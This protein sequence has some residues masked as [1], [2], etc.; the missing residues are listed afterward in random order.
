[1]KPDVVY[2]NL[3][4]FLNDQMLENLKLEFLDYLAKLSD[5]SSDGT[6]ID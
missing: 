1:M 3:L 6:V 2:I 4:T 5:V